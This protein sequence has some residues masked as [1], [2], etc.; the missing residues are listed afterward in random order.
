MKALFRQGWALGAM[1]IACA[2]H[3]EV[4]DPRAAFEEANQLYADGDYEQAVEQY[5]LLLPEHQ[6]ANVHFN[7]GNAYYQ[8][9]DYGPAILHFEKASALAP[10]NPDI[11]ANLELAQQAAQLTPEPPPWTAIVADRLSADGWAWLAMFAFWVSAALL[12]VAP[13]YRWKGP[14]RG[15]LT[16]FS[17][18]VLV[19]SI[20]GLYGWHVRASYGV[21]LSDKAT[22]SIAPTATSPSVGSVVAGEQARIRDQRGDYYLVSMGKDKTGWLNAD[23]FAPIWERQSNEGPVREG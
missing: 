16:A 4:S 1:L 20:V 21:V 22:L 17:L 3:A 19:V 5:R 2:L 11:Q 18:V 6:S 14:L 8:L 10:R 23:E 12:F 7:L 13:L 15:G 9:Q